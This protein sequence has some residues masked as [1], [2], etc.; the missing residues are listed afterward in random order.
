[1]FTIGSY[2][3]PVVHKLRAMRGLSNYLPQLYLQ[4]VFREDNLPIDLITHRQHW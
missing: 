3:F 2:T 4:F 1:M